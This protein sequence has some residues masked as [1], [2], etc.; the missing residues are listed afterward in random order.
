MVVSVSS[1]HAAAAEHLAQ[2]FNRTWN[3]RDGVGYGDAYWSDAELVD[4]TG[5]IWDGRDAIVAMHVALWNGPA[6]STVVDARVR[7]VSPLNREVIVVDL[8]VDVKGFAPAPPGAAVKENGSVQA[9]LK[10]VVQKRG[11]EWRIV[12]SQN[13]FVAALPD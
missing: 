1:E 8:E 12:S 10:H 11:D 4:P 13:T 9:R 7:R 6:R 3:G 5:Q 2:M